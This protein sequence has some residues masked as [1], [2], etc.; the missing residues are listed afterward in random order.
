LAA[1]VQ[2]EKRSYFIFVRFYGACWRERVRRRS[3]EE[4]V[5]IYKIVLFKVYPVYAVAH[6]KVMILIFNIL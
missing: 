1:V 5:N 4:N 6:F 2:R 3:L